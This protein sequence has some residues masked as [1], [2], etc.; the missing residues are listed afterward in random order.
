MSHLVPEKRMDYTGRLVTRHVAVVSASSKP[1]LIPNV[2]ITSGSEN[3]FECTQCRYTFV[4]GSEHRCR[5]TNLIAISPA[6]QRV[7]DA[8]RSAGGYPLMVGGCV[9]D[10]LMGD[11]A[12]ASKDIDIEVYGVED[13]GRLRTNLKMAGRVDEAGVSFG[14]LKIR[15]GGEDFDVSLPRRDSKITDGH[16]GFAVDFDP[17]LDEVTA[18]ARRDFTINAMA[19]DPQTEELVDPF[20]GTADLAAGILRHTTEAFDEDPLRVLRGV[21]F[22]AR[23]GFS[24]A[25]ETSARARALSDDYQHLAK[26][27]VWGEFD[28]LLTKGVH[29]SAGFNA[30]HECGWERHFPELAATRDV[31]QDAGWHPEGN[32]IEHLGLSGDAAAQIAIRDGLDADQRRV[33][34][35][36]SVFHDLGKVTHTQISPEGKIT[37]YGHAEGGVEPTKSLLQRI[38]APSHLQ[39]KVL[40]LVRE[41]MCYASVDTDVPTDSTVR[42]LIRRLEGENGRGPTIHDWARVLEADASG[43]GAGNRASK[44]GAWVAVADKIGSRAQKSI[45]RGDHLIAHGLKPSPQFSVIIKAALVA[46]DE[47]AFTDEA[48]ALEWLRQ[49]GSKL[50]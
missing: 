21:Q 2:L 29:L 41:H 32:V 34:V 48:G 38:G 10:A 18:C 1:V 5:T 26:E 25:P 6:T 50:S 27:R 46:Q 4:R 39:D 20:G 22:A 47:G 42:R 43:R 17:N 8:C 28:K 23:F 3:T 12:A 15:S 49:E 40:P 45:L 16:R 13:I 36:A 24:I 14:V 7:L 19:Y 30:L 44:G 31:P 37:S 11:G 33:I 9:R 35:A